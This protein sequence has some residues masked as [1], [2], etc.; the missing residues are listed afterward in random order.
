MSQK[1]ADAWYELMSGTELNGVAF[2][3]QLLREAVVYGLATGR[4]LDPS[5]IEF[6][7]GGQAT[8][9][10]TED[11]TGKLRMVCARLAVIFG[12]S[13]REAPTLYGGHVIGT[14]QIGNAAVNFDLE[15]SNRPGDV[16][17]RIVRLPE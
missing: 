5:Q 4:H 6:A 12:E 9:V 17:F 11:T 1:L 15:H 7:T 14:I 3:D 16:W 2:V 8:I 13:S 10:T